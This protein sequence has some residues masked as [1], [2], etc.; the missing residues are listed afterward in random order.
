MIRENFR[1][2]D[3]NFLEGRDKSTVLPISCPSLHDIDWPLGLQKNTRMEENF[4]H[5][6]SCNQT[7]KTSVISPVKSAFL[8]VWVRKTG[9]KKW[10]LLF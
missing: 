1:A 3:E 8:S 4:F 2:T 7:F 10:C 9:W 5:P 6:V